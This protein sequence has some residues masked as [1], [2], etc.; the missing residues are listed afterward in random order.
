MQLLVT[1]K[2]MTG[3]GTFMTQSKVLIGWEIRMLFST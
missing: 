3:G 2:M 1:W